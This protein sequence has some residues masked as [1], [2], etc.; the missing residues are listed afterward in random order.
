[1]LRLAIYRTS[2][3]GLCGGSD[4]GIVGVVGSGGMAEKNRGSG[5][6]GLAGSRVN[7]NNSFERGRDREGK[8]KTWQKL[9]KIG[10]SKEVKLAL[11]TVTKGK[12]AGFW[13][14][15][16]GKVMGSSWSVEDW[17]E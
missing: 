15:R 14:E 17:Q 2:S 10:N 4:G 9:R 7:R 5:V 13:W 12:G 16:V 6:A 11:Q 1:A 8:Q 3:Q